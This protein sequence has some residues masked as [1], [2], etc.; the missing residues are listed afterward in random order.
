MGTPHDGLPPAYERTLLR[1]LRDLNLSTRHLAVRGDLA[2]SLDGCVSLDRPVEQGVAYR[3]HIAGDGEQVLEL[4][5]SDG[6]LAIRVEGPERAPQTLQASFALDEHGR[7]V[8][9]ELRARVDL[10]RLDSR[11]LEHFMRRVVRSAL[12]AA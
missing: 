4:A 9:P 10:D 11:R 7:A 12:R 5:W 8:S 1:R 2:V 3:L 6:E